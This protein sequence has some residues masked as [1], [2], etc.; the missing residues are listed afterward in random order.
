[1][2]IADF[3]LDAI[4]WEL[5]NMDRKQDS[6]LLLFQEI[7][8]QFNMLEENG[9][10]IVVSISYIDDF[11]S[12]AAKALERRNGMPIGRNLGLCFAF[13]IKLSTN[14]GITNLASAGVFGYGLKGDGKWGIERKQGKLIKRAFPMTMRKL[15][16]SLSQIGSLN[17]IF[18]VKKGVLGP[19][20]AVMNGVSRVISA[21]I[22]VELLEE[23]YGSLK[24][25]LRCAV[26]ILVRLS[27]D[28]GIR[29]GM[30]R[31][32]TRRLNQISIPPRVSQP[33]SK[34]PTKPIPKQLASTQAT[35]TGP[36][37]QPPHDNLTKN[38]RLHKRGSVTPKIST[39]STEVGKESMQLM[40]NLSQ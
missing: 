30:P 33:L 15:F 7:L 27:N 28:D 4:K 3:R 6:G 23:M 38:T 12:K 17:M 5:K 40:I 11:K 29:R 22:E 25:V 18:A 37:N 10:V 1:M 36:I 16:A 20:F 21:V 9:F 31:S 32:K 19:E 34:Q 13:G 24:G 8:A 35:T 14:Q 2:I 39:K 26:T